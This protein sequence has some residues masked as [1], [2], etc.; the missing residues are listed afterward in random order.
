MAKGNRSAR[1]EL[2]LSSARAWLIAG[3]ILLVI[4]GGG[5]FL[6]E[7]PLST[8][9]IVHFNVR[10]A[11]RTSN[12]LSYMGSAGLGMTLLVLGTM[13]RRYVTR[14]LMRKREFERRQREA[15]NVEEIDSP[16]ALRKR[17]GDLL[18]SM[19]QF[20]EI[21]RHCLEQMDTMDS[22]QSKQQSLIEANDATYLNNTIDAVNRSERRICR[23]VLSIVNYC[24]VA[25]RPDKL[26]DETVRR[27]FAAN[28][29]ELS[30]VDELLRT[31]PD[32]ISQYEADRSGEDDGSDVR[33]WSTQLNRNGG[34][35]SEKVRD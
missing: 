30:E 3:I 32:S 6:V 13:L 26:D 9:V 35:M 1:E 21:F 10:W 5:F 19:P 33:L 25:E 7:Y 12:I 8:W 15:E 28:A 14:Q 16:E 18:Q 2:R 11:D 22:F 27:Y 29:K 17:I 4:G 31:M 23:N 34:K 24:Y 20:D